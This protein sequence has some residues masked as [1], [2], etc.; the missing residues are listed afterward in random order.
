MTSQGQEQ[1]VSSPGIRISCFM[2][3]LDPWRASVRRGGLTRRV[4]WPCPRAP[5]PVSPICPLWPCP[6][7]NADRVS[8][9]G[10]F[11]HSQPYGVWHDWE[12]QY[13]LGTPSRVCRVGT[14]SRTARCW[15]PLGTRWGFRCGHTTLFHIPP[16]PFS[17]VLLQKITQGTTKQQKKLL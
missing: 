16:V 3:R 4:D 8:G 15:A 7:G 2:E 5:A 17:F 13:A 14:A 10:S 9:A 11:G 6:A 12:G 1:F